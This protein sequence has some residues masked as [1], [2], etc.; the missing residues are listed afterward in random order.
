MKKR[1]SLLLLAG[2]VCFSLTGCAVNIPFLN[3]DK[4]ETTTTD[5][6]GDMPSDT[7]VLC[8]VKQNLE[9]PVGQIIT[10]LDLVDLDS[11]MIN[12]V[13]VAA[14]IDEMGMVYE[15][16]ELSE[17]GTFVYELAID[18][19]D[20]DSFGDVATVTVVDGDVL[21]IDGESSEAESEVVELPDELLRNIERYNW[22]SEFIQQATGDSA[23]LDLSPTSMVISYN[24]SV[25]ELSSPIG[26][27][28]IDLEQRDELLSQEELNGNMQVLYLPYAAE[29]ALSSSGYSP[30]VRD[31]KTDFTTELT[32]SLFDAV[33][34]W[35]GDLAEEYGDEEGVLEFNQDTDD[36]LEMSDWANQLIQGITSVTTVDTDQY[37]YD[38]E[39]KRYEIH[40]IQYVWDMSLL[41]V[42]T[43]DVINTRIAYIEYENGYLLFDLA[44]VKF[45]QMEPDE[46]AGEGEEGELPS[47]YEEFVQLVAE[48]PD[49]LNGYKN[50]DSMQTM[51]LIKQI[52][53]NMLIG[54]YSALAPEDGHVDE[55]GSI[56]IEVGGTGEEEELV[57]ANGDKILPYEEKFPTL[58]SWWKD[59]Q[60]TKEY[61]YRRWVIRSGGDYMNSDSI[62]Y[63]GSIVRK[64]GASGE[65]GGGEVDMS[66]FE[67]WILQ[68][69]G[70]DTNEGGNSNMGTG[71]MATSNYDTF[72]LTSSYADYI[73]SNQYHQNVRFNTAQSTSSRLAMSL[74]GE[75]YYIEA[76]RSTQIQNY[77]TECLY[78]TSTFRDSTYAVNEGSNSDVVTTALGRIT[79]YYISYTDLNGNEFVKPYM[80]VYDLGGDY[81]VIYADNLPQEED[82][83]FVMLLESMVTVEE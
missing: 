35:A 32:K 9:F 79:P 49:M 72:T 22:S 69:M 7:L 83:T 29:Q 62:T 46:D 43:G 31:T 20:G 26:L 28:S 53:T 75:K 68:Q 65:I 27:V 45:G 17:V 5:N 44:Y 8:S 52:S 51:G 67:D 54:D 30:F 66:G 56:D 23:P 81:I 77:I 15:S 50:D 36:L 3:K 64:D 37:I 41:G 73:I 2:L 48:N 78:S 63:V 21:A 24:S 25:F 33:L 19:A 80:A 40:E 57:G 58:F 14:L 34:S 10:A 76:V 47:S 82:G 13:S 38:V 60:S 11:S 18:F 70:G 12:Q 16:V 61:Y 6:D 39:G 59:I 71:N 74:D 4:E 55:E 1:L 42:D